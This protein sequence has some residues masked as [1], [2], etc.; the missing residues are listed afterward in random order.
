[1]QESKEIRGWKFTTEVIDD[2]ELSAAQEARELI[3]FL[4]DK[5]EDCALHSEFRARAFEEERLAAAERQRVAEESR[6][7]GED[8]AQRNTGAQANRTA[9]NLVAAEE[10]EAAA[11]KAE[12]LSE[13]SERP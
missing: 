5:Q 9:A 1:M 13:G 7:A 10:R 6:I 12:E 3:E 4:D 11:Q 8:L 2:Q